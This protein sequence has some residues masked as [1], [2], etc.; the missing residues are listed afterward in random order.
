MQKLLLKPVRLL[1][2]LALLNLGV[3]AA[4]RAA[5][6]DIALGLAGPL[7]GSNAQN[8]LEMRVGMEAAIQD[9]NSRGGVLHQKLV[10]LAED[11]G[12]DNRQ[13]ISAAKRMVEHGIHFV[14]G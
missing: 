6:A 10:L 1:S 13:A 11:D 12:C 9:I 5:L 2:L 3:A 4:P 14:Y 8:G 7:T